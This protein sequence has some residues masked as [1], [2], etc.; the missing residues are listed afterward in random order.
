M[1]RGDQRARPGSAQLTTGAEGR[2]AETGNLCLTVWRCG[3]SLGLKQL[4]GEGN[5]GKTKWDMELVEIAHEVGSKYGAILGLVGPFFLS[6]NGSFTPVNM[7]SF[8]SSSLTLI[9][10]NKI[11]AL[12]G[13]RPIA[14]VT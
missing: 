6:I 1:D 12:I 8:C 5:S 10:R 4:E 9:I 3:P 14:L 13:K 2:G 11:R 7:L